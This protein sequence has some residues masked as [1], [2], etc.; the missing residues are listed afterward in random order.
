MLRHP[1]FADLGHIC[2]GRFRAA[3]HVG[4]GHF[5]IDARREVGKFFAG[6][7][8]RFYCLF[9]GLRGFCSA[10]CGGSSGCSGLLLLV[11]VLLVRLRRNIFV[12]V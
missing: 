8:L 7:D 6:E 10:G 4:E 2:R 12:G 11:I 5:A 9:F 1:R 3:R